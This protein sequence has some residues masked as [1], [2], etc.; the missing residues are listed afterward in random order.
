MRVKGCAIRPPPQETA[1]PAH[2][3]SVSTSPQLSDCM[4]TPPKPPAACAGY[5][6]HPASRPPSRLCV[7]EHCLAACVWHHNE[8]LVHDIKPP[9]RPHIKAGGSPTACCI[10]PECKLVTRGAKQPA[11][12]KH[13]K[14]CRT[15]PHTP[16]STHN[17]R[18]ASN[19]HT[20]VTRMRV[21]RQ[22]TVSPLAT[23]HT[24]PHTQGLHTT[25]LL[26]GGGAASNR[27]LAVI[28]LSCSER[29]QISDTHGCLQQQHQAH[30][31]Q[32]TPVHP[33]RMAPSQP[34]LMY[35]ALPPPRNVSVSWPLSKL[36][37]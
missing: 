37:H 3:V 28:L 22:H 7:K 33:H 16:V 30:T 36:S 29:I 23:H 6:T 11:G 14:P 35:P 13:T 2:T 4:P 24:G 25:L 15:T 31:A 27:P 12:W 19:S 9:L 34:H 26:L 32:A 10:R 8:T 17:P 21:D 1:A 20:P 5:P 18:P